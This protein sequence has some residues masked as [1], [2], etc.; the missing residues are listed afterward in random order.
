MCLCE[1]AVAPRGHFALRR[2]LQR[3]PHALAD[4]IP[5]AAPKQE[6][7]IAL[8]AAS[9]SAVWL[10]SA[11]YAQV[12]ESRYVQR[13]Q[14]LSSILSR[15]EAAT[16]W[17]QV[18]DSGSDDALLVVYIPL[19]ATDIKEK[20]CLRLLNRVFAQHLQTALQRSLRD[21]QALCYA[22]F[23]QPYAEGEHDGLALAVQSSKVSAAQLLSE[24]RQCL[25]DFQTQL[26]V[27][28]EVL[29]ADIAVQTTQ[30]QQG[31]LGLERISTMLFR[32]W[33][34]QR[35]GVGLQDE[36]HAQAY[37]SADLIEHYCQAL[38]VRSR[39][40]LLSNQAENKLVLIG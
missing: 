26:S 3:L 1:A 2:L 38:Q 35:L 11:Q 6:A 9:Q 17:Q 30:L 37:V 39:W 20:D 33:R 31:G 12:L 21:E 15:S 18:H 7:E 10:G 8:A 24:I 36:V 4:A 29:L 32:H 13:L 22:V 34:E 28:I 25:A 5:V 23:V 14:P 16:G 27:H 40:L 19:S